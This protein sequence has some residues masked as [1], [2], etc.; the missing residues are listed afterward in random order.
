MNLDGLKSGVYM[1]TIASGTKQ[2]IKRLIME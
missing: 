1:M 2:T